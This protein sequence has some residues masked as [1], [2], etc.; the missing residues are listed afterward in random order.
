MGKDSLLESQTPNLSR[1]IV[2]I[3]DTVP[4][5]LLHDSSIPN[6]DAGE[7]S[8]YCEVIS[9]KKKVQNFF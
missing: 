7:L 9:S 4:N 3:L 1:N 5:I 2:D 8:G 6:L